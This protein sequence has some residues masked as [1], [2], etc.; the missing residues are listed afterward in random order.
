MA[1]HRIPSLGEFPWQPSVLA[2]QNTPPTTP[3]KGDRYIV[4]GVPNGAW[5]GYAWYIAT[6]SGSGW[7]FDQ[8][9]IGWKAYDLNA[10]NEKIFNGTAW[11]I[12][13]PGTHASSH[14]AG[15]GDVVD[16]DTLDTL[17]AAAFAV[18]AKGVTNGDS[19]DHIG[20][21]GA[22]IAEGALSLA[23]VTTLDVSTS[24]HGFAP[25]APND[26]AKFLRGDG[27]WAEPAAGSVVGYAQHFLATTSPM[28]ASSYHF[29]GGQAF[30]LTQLDGAQRVY[31]PKA[32][33]IKVAYITHFAATITGSGENISVYIR[34]NATTDYLIQ[35]VGNTNQLR[36]F[37]NTGLTISVAQGDFIE[38][39]IVT[40]AWATTPT[41]NRWSGI[42]YI[43]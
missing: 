35:T 39:K 6:Y 24:R 29:F 14:E 3:A 25:K 7:I 27:T 22:A 2:L 12:A 11:Q 10:L 18:A 40:P 5:T 16:A 43:E 21:D 4:G 32:G 34:K 1:L 23:D 30:T 37:S 19:H 15:G 17:H 36:V 26:T 13:V 20:G 8:P 42:V 38:I 31:V 28:T 41:G 9:S 33:T